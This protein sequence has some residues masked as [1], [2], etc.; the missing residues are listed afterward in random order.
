MLH[1]KAELERERFEGLSR[2]QASLQGATQ[3][4]QATRIVEL[5]QQ[6]AKLQVKERNCCAATICCDM[7]R[8]APVSVHR[9]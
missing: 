5:E 2:Q 3:A 8:P 1:K 4:G 9:L 6:V 7:G